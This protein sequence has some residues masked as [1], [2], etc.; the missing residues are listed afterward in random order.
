MHH[1][2]KYQIMNTNMPTTPVI[3]QSD[4]RLDVDMKVFVSAHLLIRDVNTG[5]VL[6][7]QRG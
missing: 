1:S 3:D 2:G 5:D 6:I 4:E 7:H